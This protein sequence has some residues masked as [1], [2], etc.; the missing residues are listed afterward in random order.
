MKSEIIYEDEYLVVVHKPAGIATQTARL[1]QADVESE[2]KNHF[3]S[4]EIYCIHRLD[5]PV[6]GLLVFARN[7]RIAGQLNKQ[8]ESGKLKKSYH[9]LAYCGEK[10]P[11]KEPVTLVDY[12]YK[13]NKTNLSRVV[14]KD[15]KDAKRAELT[16]TLEQFDEASGRG[17]FLVEIATGRHHQ[18]RVQMSHAGFP[19]LGDA[20]YGSDKSKELTKTLGIKNVAL[21]AD[22]IDFIH[23]I[24][25]KNIMLTIELPKTYSFV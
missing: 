2:L 12:L 16:Y 14:P 6:E 24:S 10:I 13:D 23:P 20:K 18:I 8:L 19:L 15:H 22:R 1:G 7:K 21:I 4:P 25:N 3:K 9:V 5:Q 17:L 11:A